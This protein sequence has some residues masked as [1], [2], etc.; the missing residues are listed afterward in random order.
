MKQVFTII[1]LL[2]IMAVSQL[3]NAKAQ[4]PQKMS[5]QAVVR[6]SSDKLVV[7]KVVGV[8]ISILQG[9]AT[10]TAVY[11][12]TQ[13]PTTNAN[14]LISIEIGGGTGFDQIDWSK[15]PY[16]VKTETD[17]T[18]STNYTITGTS[19]LLSVPYALH[20]ASSGNGIS[21]GKDAGNTPYW[22]GTKWV[23]DASNFYNNG[24]FIGLG[25]K[26]PSN[27]LTLQTDYVGG[28]VMLSGNGGNGP[29]F[30]L[31]NNG[32]EAGA[33]GLSNGLGNYVLGSINGDIAIRNA[34]TTRSLLF[35]TGGTPFNPRLAIIANGNVGI[36]TITPSAKLEVAGNVKIVDGTQGY[37][38]VLTSDSNGMASWK[39]I[40]SGGLSN[41]TAAG[42][43][44]Y[45]NGTTWVTNSSSI[46]NNGGFIGI[47][48]KNPSNPLTLQT[49]YVGGGVMLS[50]NGGN[51]P[52]Y[53]L[54]NN[55]TEA[56]A[57]GLS[58][59]PGNYIVGSQSGDIALRNVST[60]RSLL[61]STGGGTYIP[62]LAILANGNVGI[63]TITPMVKFEVNSDA[64]RVNTSNTPAS[65]SA[66][67][68]TG[69]IRWD[70]GYIYVCTS[71]DGPS[72]ATDTWKRASLSTW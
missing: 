49:D 26:T 28:G 25:T 61:F 54:A 20:A 53:M 24:G 57:L 43:T 50:G 47:G 29:S 7:N 17:P 63:A 30:M 34:S 36:G 8:K 71:G 38:K 2:V 44:P 22:N 15:G 51:G 5:Y 65:S 9:S 14:G 3:Q 56:G 69:E 35:S 58:N 66:S 64:I 41:G 67:G 27:P 37:G 4:S 45:W 16:F 72:G 60:T 12:E 46:Y 11:T 18:G 52:G 55:G 19:Q 13:T 32:T 1:T 23:T 62:R 10:G 31:A 21:A 39:T 33:F 42:N 70:A 40:S 48:T 68:Y 59:G 6:N